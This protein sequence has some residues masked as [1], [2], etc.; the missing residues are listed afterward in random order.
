MGCRGSGATRLSKPTHCERETVRQGPRPNFDP[1]T[2]RQKRHRAPILLRSFKIR[3]AAEIQ[4]RDP[5]EMRN[6]R[7][8][9]VHRGNLNSPELGKQSGSIKSVWP[10]PELAQ[11]FSLRLRQ[12]N[13]IRWCVRKLREARPFTRTW[14]LHDA[15]SPNPDLRTYIV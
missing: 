3:R 15:Y 6:L 12:Q 2:L 9:A 10:R 13:K 1:S 11:Y 4:F 7:I 14:E 5:V 8:F